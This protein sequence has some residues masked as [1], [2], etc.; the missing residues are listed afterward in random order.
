MTK[1]VGHIVGM[2]EIHKRK[3]IN[4][5][6]KN[7]PSIK[8]LIQVKIMLLKLLYERITYRSL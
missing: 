5:L 8:T 6:A 7:N 1:I 4:S 3:F 2:D